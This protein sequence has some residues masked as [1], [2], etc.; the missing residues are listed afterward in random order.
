MT[1]GIVVQK[2]TSPKLV[3]LPTSRNNGKEMFVRYS[4]TEVCNGPD[5][6]QN[7]EEGWSRKRCLQSIAHGDRV[8]WREEVGGYFRDLGVEPEPVR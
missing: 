1:L 7:E 2:G 5:R 3:C 8:E 6:A 4:V